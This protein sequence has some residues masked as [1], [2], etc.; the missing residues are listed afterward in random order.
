MK[1]TQRLLPLLMIAS[2]AF[3]VVGCSSQNAISDKAHTSFL[4]GDD[5]VE[6]TDKMAAGIASDS[7]VAAI[8]AQKPMVIVLQPVVN[9]TNEIMRGHEREL[10]VHRVRVLLSSK[11]VL[12]RQFTFVLNRNDYQTLLNQEGVPA[13]ELGA[14]ADRIV[15]EFALKGHF[16]ADTRA[17]SKQRSDYYL[18]TYQ[19][20]RLSGPQAGEIIWEG[21]YETK[22]AIKK[23]LL[24]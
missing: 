21:T 6:M 1:L 24:D 7:Q 20:T 15:P 22:K 12:R 17:N 2:T 13:T 16:F 9:D 23:D 8:S 18:C 19:L 11:Q 14:P 10:Y 3:F 4:T 5:V